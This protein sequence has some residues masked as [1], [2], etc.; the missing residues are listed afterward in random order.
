MSKGDQTL[1]TFNRGVMSRYAL[2]RLDLKRPAASAVEQTNFIPRAPGPML[3]RP[4]LRFLGSLPV[5]T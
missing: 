5:S 3:F 2:A 1:L 4:G